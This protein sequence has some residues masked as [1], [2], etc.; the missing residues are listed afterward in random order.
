MYIPLSIC[1]YDH[2]RS[3]ERGFI[4]LLEIHSLFIVYYY[5]ISCRNRPCVVECDRVFNTK[6]SELV[7]LSLGVSLYIV[8]HACLEQMQSDIL[9]Y[10]IYFVDFYFACVTHF[11]NFLVS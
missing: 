2:E 1:K 4:L 3:A 11:I 8:M 5:L 6:H 7:H 9:Q 10:W